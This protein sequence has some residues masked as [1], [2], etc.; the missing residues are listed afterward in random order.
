MNIFFRVDSNKTTGAGHLAR[1]SF[2]AT[3]IEAH[4]NYQTFFILNAGG[5]IDRDFLKLKNQCLIESSDQA[6]DALQTIE[7]LRKYSGPKAL[8]LDSYSHDEF[9]ESKIKPHVDLLVVIDDLADRRHQCDILIDCGYQRIETDYDNKVSAE[10]QRFIG[11]KYCFISDDIFEIKNQIQIPKRIHI[12]FGSTVPNELVLSYFINLKSQLPEYTYHLALTENLNDIQIEKWLSNR[13]A[14]DALFV[15]RPLSESL[16]GCQL[17]IGAPGIAT[18]ERAFL[19]IPGLYIATHNNQIE[20][21]KSLAEIDF[22]IF[23]G[24]IDD[25]LLKNVLLIQ[26][27]IKVPTISKIMNTLV[28]KVDGHGLQ[29]ILESITDYGK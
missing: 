12:Y 1:C 25:D 20:I 28:D 16:L 24:S 29:R 17:A 15:G 6:A 14:A 26:Q 27:F 10:T 23:I 22:C 11:L 13:S 2:L 5:H 4:S 7:I 9:W 18:W 8:I 19:G 3:H 21:I